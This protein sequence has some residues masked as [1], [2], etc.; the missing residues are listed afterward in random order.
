MRLLGD[1]PAVHVA[2]AGRELFVQALGSALVSGGEFGRW[3]DSAGVLAADLG[4]LGLFPYVLSG[5]ADV[6]M[7]MSRSQVRL[8][9]LATIDDRD[10]VIGL[11]SLACLDR[12]LAQVAD[13]AVSVEDAQSHPGRDVDAVVL[14]EPSLVDVFVDLAL[15]AQ[16]A[17]HWDELIWWISNNGVDRADGW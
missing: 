15:P 12:Q 5:F 9:M 6:A 3:A 2:D 8:A 1:R 17:A 13:A 10:D 4:H 16:S 11:P 14:A 7:R